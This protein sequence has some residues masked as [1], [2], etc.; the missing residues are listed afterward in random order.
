MI[1]FECKGN[2]TF[3]D[4]NGYELSDVKECV[5]WLDIGFTYQDNSEELRCQIDHVS[6]SDDKRESFQDAV[7]LNIECKKKL[8]D[9]LLTRAVLSM[10]FF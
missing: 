4:H 1:I 8:T 3:K 9:S 7:V 2:R 5:T 10:V 6:I